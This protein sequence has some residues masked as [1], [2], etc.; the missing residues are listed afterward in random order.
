MRN[1]AILTFVSIDGVMQAPGAPE[2][3]PSG[4]FTRGGWAAA[5]WEE[6]MPQVKRRAMTEPYDILFGR[7]T[8]DIFSGH[9]PN[10]PK[11]D[12]ADILNNAQ[13]HVVT[14]SSDSLTWENSTP[15][16][17]DAAAE[18][19]H[20][21]STK[22]PLLQVH[23]SSELI[24]T[25][26]AHDL[27]DEYRIWRFPVILG[28]GKRLFESGAKAKNLVLERSTTLENGVVEQVFRPT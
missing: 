14:S 7:K 8:Y 24:Q 17:G 25:L 18:I 26:H 10:A 16:S 23:G 5:Y 15:L 12:V 1:L 6:T 13:K 28:K 19:R 20:L 4:G 3:D 11:S 22:G 21:K 27:I 2:E 9:W